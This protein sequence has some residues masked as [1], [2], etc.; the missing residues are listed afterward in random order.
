M[1][2]KDVAVANLVEEVGGLAIEAQ[3]AGHEG[4]EFQIG[5]R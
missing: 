2:Q 5:V 3:L 1:M 4:L